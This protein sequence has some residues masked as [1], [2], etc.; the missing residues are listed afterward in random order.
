MAFFG[1]L[2]NLYRIS[3]C[4]APL[5][6]AA[7]GFQGEIPAAAPDANT[8]ASPSTGSAWTGR[9]GRWQLGGWG[10]Q[11]HLGQPVPHTNH[12]LQLPET[13]SRA[14]GARPLPSPPCVCTHTL[15]EQ[16]L[17]QPGTSVPMD[18]PRGHSRGAEQ[19]LSNP[20]PEFQKKPRG[21]IRA[22]FKS[23]HCLLT[24]RV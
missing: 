10:S 1:I 15:A 9:G 16:A 22:Q 6:A 17:G 19:K 23:Q 4:L 5:P 13:F 12:Q 8:L 3:Q 24:C 14:A 20:W 11:M 7:G 18:Q 21:Y 2:A